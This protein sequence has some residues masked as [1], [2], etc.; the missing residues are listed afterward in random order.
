MRYQGAEAFR[1]ADVEREFAREPR[2]DFD[3]VRGG[4]ID[5]EVRRGVSQG[6]L[7]IARMAVFAIALF[8]ALG[9][10]RVAITTH[11]VNCLRANV[12]LRSNI[13]EAQALNSEL[14][15]ERSVLSSSSRICRIAIQNYGMVYPLRHET[16]VLPSNEETQEGEVEAEVKSEGTAAIEGNNEAQVKPQTVQT[17]AQVETQEGQN[18]TQPESEAQPVATPQTYVPFQP[19]TATRTSNTINPAA[20]VAAEEPEEDDGVLH[21]LV[22]PDQT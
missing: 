13:D 4:G 8:V 7:V 14:R 21:E 9:A 19:D 17:E 18:M 15:M 6:F 5:A 11:T 1:Y 12:T 3:V 16:I 10:C 20:P 22:I 2:R